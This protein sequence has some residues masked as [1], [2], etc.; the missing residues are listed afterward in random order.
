MTSDRLTPLL[1][2]T[3]LLVAACGAGELTTREAQSLLDA[4][5]GAGQAE[6]LG[7]RAVNDSEAVARIALTGGAR[8]LE[9]NVAFELFDTGWR[10]GDVEMAGRS[11]PFSELLDATGQGMQLSTMASMRN[12]ATANGTMRVDVGN[13]ADALIELEMNGYMTTVPLRDAWGNAFVYTRGNETYTI[14]SL[15]SDGQAGPAPP[16]TWINAPFEPDI[17]LRDGQ[18]VQAPT[19]RD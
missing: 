12:V 13:Y 4:Q 16:A 14:T 11:F 18:F 2:S 6:V 5:L 7:I 19:G 9:I 1:F 3:A 8:D 10:P 17:V 15:G